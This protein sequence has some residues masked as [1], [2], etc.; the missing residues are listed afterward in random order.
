[1][2]PVAITLWGCAILFVL[3]IFD[4]IRRET[5]KSTRWGYAYDESGFDQR[6]ALVDSVNGLAI[7]TEKF[8]LC[9]YS[10]N[11]KKVTHRIFSAK[12]VIGCEILE[13][14]VSTTT[15]SRGSQIGGAAVG[16]LLLGGVGLLAGALTGKKKTSTIIKRID[17]RVTVND[18]YNPIH[19]VCLM[20]T[21]GKEISPTYKPQIELAKKWAAMIEILIRSANSTNQELAPPPQSTN[22]SLINTSIAD[23]LRKLAE[24][25]AEGILTEDEFLLQKTRLLE[26]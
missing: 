25:K 16:G 1:M 19:S 9:L 21:D 4:L 17:F 2:S 20:S 26:A 22:A 14:G 13:D 23:E 18:I 15:A 8:R 5:N 11:G 6:S 7:D 10:D 24:L 12:D 3:Y